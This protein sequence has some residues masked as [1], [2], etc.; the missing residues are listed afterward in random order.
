M[1]ENQL[2]NITE[3]LIDKN[4]VNGRDNNLAI[5]TQSG[6]RI[7]YK[8]LHNRINQCGNY[9]KHQ[10]LI[11]G[12]KV[13]LVI[14]D[15][16]EFFYMFLGAIRSGFI[17]VP[18]NTAFSETEYGHIFKDSSAK[19]LMYSEEF[20]AVIENTLQYNRELN[21]LKVFPVTDEFN[22][23]LEN[24]SHT[25]IVD[26]G[27]ASR[28]CFIL[29]S[30][31]STGNPK[32][33]PHSHENMISTCKDYAEDVLNIS[34]KDIIFSAAKL[35]FA[36]GLGN[37]LS[38]PL[39]AGATVI[40]TDQK[41][42][43]EVVNAIFKEF[44]PTLFFGV[45]SL[46]AALLNSEI[47]KNIEFNSLRLCISAGEALPAEIYH[48]W[49]KLTGLMVLDG[50]GTTE[51]LHIFITNRMKENCIGTSGKPIRGCQTQILN[52][53]GQEVQNG[54]P[55]RLL[56]KSN[57]LASKY[58][59]NPIKTK[60]TFADGWLNTGDIYSVDEN[61]FY[62]YCGRSDDMMKVNGMWC[63][64]FEIESK[65]IEHKHVIEAAVVGKKDEKGLLKP[66]AYI[67]INDN[68]LDKKLL[69]EELK[70]KCINELI[71]YKHPRW[72]EVLDELPKTSTG[73]IQRFKLR[74]N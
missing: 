41:A 50:I 21:N 42:N 71:S 20:E 5:I 51:A 36:Y 72:I 49:N 47:F 24:Q 22:S 48:Q 28:D 45:P 25:L 12:D 67:V 3:Y 53:D 61:G 69:C 58:L 38:F 10:G 66:Y 57:S 40:L 39:W 56:I 1:N 6:E 65:L 32:G 46:Y 74:I 37:S 62:H 33:V 18:I 27:L 43:D 13:A 14:K 17:P 68:Q 7:T 70:T 9:F 44:K 4:L 30:S 29:Y 31:G 63:S 16:P 2:M 59:N 73:K 60:T 23:L 55:G 15:C 54:T 19:L 52:S 11:I 8:H 26:K 35:F 64:P 34:P